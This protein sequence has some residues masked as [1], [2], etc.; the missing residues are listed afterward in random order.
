MTPTSVRFSSL[1]SRPE[2]ARA[3]LADATPIWSSRPVRRTVLASSQSVGT[4]PSTSP[5]A[6]P[7]YGSVSNRVI[8]PIP[9]RPLTRLSQAVALSL[10]TGLI[11][12]RPVM[13]TRRS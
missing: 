7:A 2:S 13:T 10:P 5:P 8:W 4:K 3:S 9:L 6:L 1:I 12:P 11:R